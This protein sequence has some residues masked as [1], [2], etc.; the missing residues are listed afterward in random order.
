M[1]IVP[2]DPNGQQASSQHSADHAAVFKFLDFIFDGV[3]HGFIEF[4]Y[5]SSGRRPKKSDQPTF[6]NLPLQHEQVAN[7]VLNRNGQRMIAVGLAPRCRIPAKGR[8]G[9]NQDILQIGCVWANLDN[10]QAPGGAIDIIR[11]IKNFPLRPSVV[12]NSGY[13]YHV[14]FVFHE[15]LQAGGLLVW[16]K[17]VEMLRA[18]LGVDTMANLSEVMRLTGTLNIKEAYPATG[19]R[20][21]EY[22]RRNKYIYA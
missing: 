11:R 22:S 5:F 1:D 2:P 14:Y 7:E 20:V 12:V 15:Y 18:L 10:T 8:A 6:L 13:G 16:S 4:Q 19:E 9:R 3:E 17:L 21:E